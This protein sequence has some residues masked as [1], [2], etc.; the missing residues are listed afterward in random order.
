M[1][2]V[3]LRGGSN[4]CA[5][6][7]DL[8]QKLPIRHMEPPVSVTETISTQSA[9]FQIVGTCEKFNRRF[10]RVIPETLRLKV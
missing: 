6:T 3:G 8:A 5:S 10:W 9:V 7:V 4:V 1:G 2:F